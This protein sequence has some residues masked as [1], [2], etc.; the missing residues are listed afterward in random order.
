MI[1][2]L[3]SASGRLALQRPGLVLASMLVPAL[4][5][6]YAIRVPLDFSFAGVMNRAHPGVARYFA[7]SERYGLGGLLPVLVEGREQSLDEAVLE[8][9]LALD[10]LDVVRSVA[11]D[12]PREWLLAR[13]P[14]L[15]DAGTF[16]R[17]LAL[18]DRFVAGQAASEHDLAELRSALERLERRHLPKPP[19]GSRLVVVSMASD[20]FE[21]ALDSDHFPVIRD[22]ARR[23]LAP[24]GARARFAGMPAIIS[25]DQEATL[26]RMRVLAPVSLIGVLLLLRLME[27]RPLMLLSVALPMLL[28][29]GMTLGSIGAIAGSLGLM[30]AVFGVLVFGLGIDFAIHLMLRLRE[31]RS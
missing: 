18:A 2:R 15:V 19:E 4:C 28:S 30:E 3:L 14:Y 13:A 8:L 16:G 9:R 6:L 25:Q 5:S 23:A 11:P 26:S 22:A 10:D 20:S 1:S 21:L 31:E 27:R 12:P 24:F 29:V 17:W 7:A